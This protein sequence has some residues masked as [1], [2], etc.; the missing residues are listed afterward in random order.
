MNGI[1]LIFQLVYMSFIFPHQLLMVI[2]I[3]NT[4]FVFNFQSFGIFGIKFV[5]C[6]E[7]FS[8]FT[9]KGV[10]IVAQQK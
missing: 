2:Y 8:K 10:P 1:L 7:Q 6:K 3:L 9:V 4:F 5:S